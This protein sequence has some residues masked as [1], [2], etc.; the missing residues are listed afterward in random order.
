MLRLKKMMLSGSLF[1]FA[2]M[3]TSCIS[4]RKPIEMEA[5][6]P[7][8]EFIMGKWATESVLFPDGKSTTFAYEV[9]FKDHNTVEVVVKE[10]GDPM[11]LTISE[12]NFI[13]SN[14]IFV[15]NKR[16]LGGE[17]WVLERDGQ[18]LKI[19]IKVNNEE[20][21]DILILVRK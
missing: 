21:G 14:T 3:L 6:I 16:N 2:A 12:Y 17:E 20:E 5:D 15:D 8:S 18:K 7:L 13:N 9:D 1:L 10:F 19:T 11:Y 4:E